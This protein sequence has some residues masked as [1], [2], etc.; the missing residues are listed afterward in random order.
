MLK[1]FVI[2]ATLLA[3]FV[4]GGRVI[5]IAYRPSSSGSVLLPVLDRPG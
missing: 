2:L 4:Q 5:R 1:E 3:L